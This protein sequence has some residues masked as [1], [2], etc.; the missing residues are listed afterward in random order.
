VNAAR[1][2]AERKRTCGVDAHSG[3]PLVLLLRALRE[4]SDLAHDARGQGDQ[5][6]GGEAVGGLVRITGRAAQRSRGDDVRPRGRDLS[7]PKR[8]KP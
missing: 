3:Q 1:S 2:A 4:L 6:P 8:A 7:R 5:I